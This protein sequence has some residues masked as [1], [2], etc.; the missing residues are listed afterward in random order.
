MSD[1]IHQFGELYGEAGANPRPA[2]ASRDR[3]KPG[4]G[5]RPRVGLIYNA[6]SHRNKGQ[7]LDLPADVQVSVGQPRGREQIAEVLADFAAQGIDYLIINGGDGTVRDV[8]TAGHAI[9]GD[10]WPDLA[11]LPKGKT[12][13]LNVDLGAPAGW[14]VCDAIAA[15]DSGKRIVRRP[16]E[17]AATDGPP[18]AVRGFIFGAGAFT[19]GVKAGQDAHKMG[20]FDSLAVGVTSVWGGLQVIFG[21]D[22][23][24]WRR[25][26]EMAITL[27]PGDVPMTRSAFGDPARRAIMFASTLE[28]FPMG[29]Q[30]FG[31]VEENVKLTVLDHP[32]RRLMMLLPAIL[33]GYRPKWLAKAGLHQTSAEAIGIDIADQFILDGEAFPAGQ[34]RIGQGAPLQFVVP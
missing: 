19:I 4:S 2:A 23:N 5:V 7:D 22:S 29:V 1:P 8:L 12:N 30:L 16:L 28:R 17:V 25:G 21:T 24:V 3:V 31:D 6:R 13:A 34:Y 20:A 11:V 26:V 18:A 14:N 10:D 32:R 27:Q 9:F 33:F 15:W